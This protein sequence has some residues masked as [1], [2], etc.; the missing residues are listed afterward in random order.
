MERKGYRVTTAM[1]VKEA[2]RVFDEHQGKFD[3]IFTEAMFPDGTGV[4][5]LEKLLTLYHEIPGLL[6]SGYTDHRAMVDLARSNNIVFLHKTYALA[7]LYE[8]VSQVL[9]KDRLSLAS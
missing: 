9:T 3:L 6:S 5:V 4:E 8:T 7:S 2:Y 1:S